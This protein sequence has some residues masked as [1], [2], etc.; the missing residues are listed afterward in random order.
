[1]PGPDPLTTGLTAGAAVL[2]FFGG[3]SAAK[4]QKEMAR[5]QAQTIQLQNQNFLAAQP[6][7]RQALE[8]AARFAGLGGGV[9]Q[10]A[11]GNFQL[12][13]V[14]G[15]AGYGSPEDR[16]RFQTAEEDINRAEKMRRNQLLNQYARLGIN[17]GAQ[18][19]GLARNASLAQQQLG[20]FR[21]QQAINAPL[22]QQQRLAFLQNLISQGFG[23]GSQAAA[24]FGQQ[25]GMY[26]QQAN[27]AF[28]DLGNLVQNY[29]YQ[30]MLAKL[31][32]PAQPAL[33]GGG[34]PGP[35]S[36]APWAKP[37]YQ[38]NWWDQIEG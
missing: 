23:Q 8:Q 18:A 6:Y 11:N 38:P 37:G 24:G 27:Q 28:G 26:G 2:D 14:P 36:T 10:G 17:Q 3:R 25:A 5:R 13:G 12:G 21:R 31:Q 33:G 20:Q 32:N 1:M 7:Y 30:N 22:E 29:Q 34:Y 9:T 19:A 4:S 15:T 16:L 35:T